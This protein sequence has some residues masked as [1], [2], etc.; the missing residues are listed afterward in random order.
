MIMCCV[1][2]RDLV[3]KV[4]RK[5]DSPATPISSLLRT[6]TCMSTFSSVCAG[7]ILIIQVYTYSCLHYYDYILNTFCCVISHLKVFVTVHN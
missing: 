1:V 3:V 4:S 6:V 7:K 5:R 2:S